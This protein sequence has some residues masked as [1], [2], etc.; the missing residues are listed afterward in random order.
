MSEANPCE[1]VTPLALGS[2]QV[3]GLSYIPCN[4]RFLQIPW[5]GALSKL[6]VGLGSLG[7][8]G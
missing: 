5:N 6:D 7:R 1:L 4:V 3:P 8:L 2:R